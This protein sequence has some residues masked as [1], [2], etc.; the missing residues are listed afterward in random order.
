MKTYGQFCPLARALDRVGDRW[1][2]LIVRDLAAGPK[3]YTDLLRGLPGIGTTLL[4]DRL[5]RLE[6]EGVVERR[7]LPAPAASTVYELTQAG[8]ELSSALVPLAS[9]G[10]RYL[11]VNATEELRPEWIIMLWQQHIERENAR[12]VHDLYEF[13]VDGQP[14]H[15]AIDDGELTGGVSPAPRA[16][17]VRV[18]TDWQ[19]FLE[20]GLGRL[21]PLDPAAA[22]RGAVE[23]DDA[24]V[25]RFFEL[26]VAPWRGREWFD[27]PARVADGPGS[28]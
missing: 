4:A 18:T 15:V 24:A 25:A 12:G 9:W 19:T 8:R 16:P 11:G 21:D 3:R 1:T 13:V 2:P 23:G 20:V 17:D 22:T 27:P 10:L 28:R 26:L 14:F 7:E 6:E 5:R